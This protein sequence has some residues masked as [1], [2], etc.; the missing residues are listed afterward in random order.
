MSGGTLMA[1]VI[2]GLSLIIEHEPDAQLNWE[3]DVIY[4]GDLTKNY[5]ADDIRRLEELGWGINAE[6]DCFYHF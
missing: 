2:T 1:Q 3:H 6:Y 4:A 5:S